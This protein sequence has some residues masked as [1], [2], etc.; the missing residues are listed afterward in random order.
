MFGAR[1]VRRRNVR[2]SQIHTPVNPALPLAADRGGAYAAPRVMSQ[3]TFMA[4]G[5]RI[6]KQGL[7]GDDVVELQVRLAL[8]P[9]EVVGRASTAHGLLAPVEAT[10]A[11]VRVFLPDLRFVPVDFE[12]GEDWMAKLAAAGLKCVSK[13][14]SIRASLVGSTDKST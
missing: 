13:S 2:R 12:Q 3:E 9:R 14:C 7:N 8:G 11:A 5:D 4:Y 6:L 1:R 10:V